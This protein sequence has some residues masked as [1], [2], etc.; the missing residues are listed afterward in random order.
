[1]VELALSFFSIVLSLL[2]ECLI[3][4]VNCFFNDCSD[5]CLVYHSAILQGLIIAF[6]LVP[7]SLCLILDSPA[8]VSVMGI[9]VTMNH[10]VVSTFVLFG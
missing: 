2:F 7:L 3:C 4:T 9:I 6:T 10:T 8:V 5:L 1:M